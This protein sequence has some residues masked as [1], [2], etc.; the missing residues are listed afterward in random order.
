M[1]LDNIKIDSK[2]W[3]IRLTT[4]FK[5]NF[6]YENECISDEDQYNQV[7]TPIPLLISCELPS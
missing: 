2:L 6:E 5:L 4:G 7:K 3:K 1:Q